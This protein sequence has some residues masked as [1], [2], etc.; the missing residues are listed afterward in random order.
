[1]DSTAPTHTE[2]VR[3]EVDS[4]PASNLIQSLSVRAARDDEETFVST[5]ED[6]IEA[7]F[8]EG[9]A[10]DIVEAPAAQ[11]FEMDETP[12]PAVEDEDVTF[13][14]VADEATFEDEQSDVNEQDEDAQ[15][16]EEDWMTADDGVH[17]EDRGDVFEATPV[18]EAVEVGPEPG[19][20]GR[21]EGAPLG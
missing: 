7:L 14:D 11:V 3:S 12:E 18:V 16:E 10:D 19:D 4:S 9:S 2:F 13:D 6:P 5:E 1:M 17:G 21:A 20:E 8:H 15:E